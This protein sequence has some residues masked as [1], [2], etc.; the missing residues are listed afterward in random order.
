MQ[1]D[2]VGSGQVKVASAAAPA[3]G[4]EANE[5]CFKADRPAARQQHVSY[6]AR[7]TDK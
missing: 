4:A 5:R 2:N 6:V 1:Q 7:T 3:A